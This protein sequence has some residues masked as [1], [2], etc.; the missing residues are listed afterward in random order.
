M[1]N[2]GCFSLPFAWKL[3]GK[4]VSFALT[5]VIAGFNWYGNHI[6]V[7]SSQHLAKK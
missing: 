7:R 2:A 5:F 4:W 1:F 6:L 3:G